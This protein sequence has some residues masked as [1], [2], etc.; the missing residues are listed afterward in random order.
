MVSIKVRLSDGTIAEYVK[1]KHCPI[2]DKEWQH[3]LGY[4][5]GFAT[6]QDEGL[7]QCTEPNEGCYI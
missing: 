5:W 6:N 4:C 7:L 2:S 1:P 3:P